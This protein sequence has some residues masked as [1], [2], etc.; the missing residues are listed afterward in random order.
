MRSLWTGQSKQRSRRGGRGLLLLVLLGVCLFLTYR[1]EGEDVR[2]V[3]PPVAGQVSLRGSSTFTP[4][5]VASYAEHSGAYGSWAP[6]VSSFI[7]VAM[8]VAG[9]LMLGKRRGVTR[10]ARRP[11]TLTSR[12]RSVQVNKHKLKKPLEAVCLSNAPATREP[13]PE[14]DV[15][16]I[17]LDT[18]GAL[19]YLEGQSIGI[20]PPGSKTKVYSIAS[21]GQG[22]LA[23]GT[24]VSLCVKRLVEVD[25]EHGE[26]EVSGP[27][28]GHKVYRGVGSNHLC[29]LEPGDKVAV[30]GPTGKDLLLPEDPESKVLMLATGTGIAPFRGFLSSEFSGRT[31]GQHKGKFWLILGVADNSAILYPEELADYVTSD[32]E[33]LRIDYAL[34]REDKDGEGRKMYIQNKMRQCGDDIWSWLQDP[35]FHLYMCGLKAME[36]GVHEALADICSSHGGDWQKILTRMRKEGRYHAE[37]Y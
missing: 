13:K 14:A 26:V 37:V 33:R 11:K 3:S 9:L 10:Q 6:S 27:H 2:F 32:P 36:S 21:A 20:I 22:D 15:R 23:D 30:T 5:V 1:N 12:G 35:K 34:S 7:P 16:H 17:V 28:A 25:K 4:A 24:T 18:G 8:V 29:D 31:K 19:E